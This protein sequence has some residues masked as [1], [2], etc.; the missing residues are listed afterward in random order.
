M[1]LLLVPGL[2]S[3]TLLLLVSLL[4]PTLAS[5]G[6]LILPVALTELGLSLL[7]ARLLAMLL[8][9]LLALLVLSLERVLAVLLVVLLS[10]TLVVW[11]VL[12][13]GKLSVGRIRSPGAVRAGTRA[14][15][16]RVGRCP[17]AVRRQTMAGPSS[18]RG[19][20]P[21]TYCYRPL[22]S[23][24]AHAPRLTE[25]TG[26]NGRPVATDVRVRSPFRPGGGRRID[27]VGFR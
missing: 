4:G 17:A 6:P 8:P 14:S 24:P 20:G 5:L 22:S 7:V 16:L 3:L 11:C 26:R 1:A 23:R 27:A 18:V 2:V 21:T 15:E 12:I 13:H 9:G 19:L 25:S 10:S